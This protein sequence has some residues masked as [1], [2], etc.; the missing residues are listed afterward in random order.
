MTIV[1]KWTVIE[2]NKLWRQL[3]FRTANIKVNI[4]SFSEFQEWTYKINVKYNRKKYSWV[5]AYIKSKWVFESHIFDFDKDIYWK[6]IEVFIL[7][8][9]RDNK[10]FENLDEL[11]KQ[12]SRDIIEAKKNKIKVITFWTYDVFH[13]WHKSF[14]RQASFYWDELVTIIATDKN[15]E[16]IKWIPPRNNENIR[17][18]NLIKWWISDIVDLW[19]NTN[20]L[21]CFEKYNPDIVCVGYDQTWFLSV[22]SK[23]EKYKSIGIVR[24]KPYN[25]KVYKSSLMK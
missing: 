7:K 20:P 23:S 3:W 15:V 14:L 1:L 24:L 25:P 17:K 4:W 2:W 12:I 13:P 10:K 22:L 11:K 8:K 6:K 21:E 9:I 5:W 18:E 19:S 16:K